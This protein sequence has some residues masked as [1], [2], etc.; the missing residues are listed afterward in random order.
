MIEAPRRQPFV[1]T[2]VTI[3]TN[4]RLIWLE[5]GE[6]DEPIA[7]T[8]FESLLQEPASSP[9]Q[10][11]AE[12]KAT[13]R[14]VEYFALAYT[15][16]DATR[17]LPITVNGR[18][19]EIT[20][21]LHEFLMQFRERDEPDAWRGP[22]W[23]D[24]LCINQEDNEEKSVQVNI[25]G[26]IYMHTVC[27]IAWLSEE[28]EESHLAFRLIRAV[29]Y[30]SRHVWSTI[31]WESP[32]KY[33]MDDEVTPS[34]GLT[35]PTRYKIPAG[36]ARIWGYS[37]PASPFADEAWIALFK[38]LSRPWFERIWTLQEFVILVN[39]EVTCGSQ[40]VPA[41]MLSLFCEMSGIL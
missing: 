2:P 15:W 30:M 28:E 32:I 4:M 41:R 7:L 21:N 20:Y 13:L 24:A 14:Y 9:H 22:F 33:H 1:H 19:F 11:E 37:D 12:D 5:P 38:L 35:E 3:P 26:D 27:C 40:S 10:S 17:R 29:E 25:M 31:H 34:A 6:R 8:M 39:V 36:R 18:A 16:G 23:I